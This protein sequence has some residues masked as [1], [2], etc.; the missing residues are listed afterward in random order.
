MLESSITSLL[1]S[2]LLDPSSV[3][4]CRGVIP[5]VVARFLSTFCERVNPLRGPAR[6]MAKSFISVVTSWEV[7]GGRVN[8]GQVDLQCIF[9]WEVHLDG[10]GILVVK[11]SD[12]PVGT[13][14]GM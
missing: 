13:M 10:S 8:S 5:E 6:P 11:A 2:R 1:P 14:P 4:S 12:H 3:R 9:L 7:T